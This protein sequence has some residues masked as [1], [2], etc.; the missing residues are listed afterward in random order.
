MLM[1]TPPSSP[2]IIRLSVSIYRLLIRGLG[3]TSYIRQYGGLTIG[4][5]RENCQNAYRRRGTLGVLGLWSP[6]FR[7][8]V[9]Q[10]VIEV[11]CVQQQTS[12]P[13]VSAAT[14]IPALALEYF[15]APITIMRNFIHRL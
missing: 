13:H 9:S 7:D 14:V 15:S 10:M 11:L 4:L 2:W 12:Q 8:A 3:P 5:F 6:S 1:R